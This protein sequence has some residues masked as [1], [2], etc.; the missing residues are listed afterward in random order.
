MSNEEELALKQLKENDS[1]II[2]KADKGN[3]VVII[4]KNDYIK[5]LVKILNDKVKFI[6]VH[7]PS[8]K[9][10]LNILLS[11]EKVIVEFLKTLKKANKEKNQLPGCITDSVY[12]KLYPQG[13][14]PGRMYGNA[15]VH[16]PLEDGVPKF[17]PII[18]A[19]GTSSYKIAK[20]L[21]PILKPY[22]NNEYSLSDS[23]KFK[24][25]ILNQRAN[26]FMSTMDIE[27]LFTNLPLNETIDI[28]VQLVVEHNELVDGL[29]RNE[30]RR[31]L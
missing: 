28:C 22:S 12:W 20:F 16:K 18:S 14:K 30:F 4:N 8:D 17:R 24:Q 6:E 11:Q 21:L 1:I 10:I 5:S 31:L 3:V 26:T 25:E 7:I 13:T 15:K 29:N 23:F 27:S 2:Q 9:E 19:I